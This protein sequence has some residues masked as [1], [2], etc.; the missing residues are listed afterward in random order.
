M[1]E[2]ISQLPSMDEK[3]F[4]QSSLSSEM[5]DEIK[6]VIQVTKQYN[7]EFEQVQRENNDILPDYVDQLEDQLQNDGV[8]I[9]DEVT[10]PE[11]K[12]KEQVFQLHDIP[13]EFT[14]DYLVLELPNQEEQRFEGEDALEEITLPSNK[15]GDFT[16]ELN[17]RLQEDLDANLQ[18]FDL[19]NEFAEWQWSL[20]QTNTEDE[21][22]NRNPDSHVTASQST[23]HTAAP[24]EL[25]DSDTAED[26]EEE[27]NSENNDE[28]DSEDKDDEN[29]ESEE[30]D[31]NDNDAE[32]NDSDE[33]D[34][35]T[36]E[37]EDKEE[38]KED[39][40]EEDSDSNENNDENDDSSEDKDDNDD[41]SEVEEV[42]VT[43]NH[44][45]HQVTKPI[46]D[47]TTE[48]LIHSVEDTI[49]PYQKLL[50][51]YETYFDI[52]L[53][54]EST[55]GDCAS[56]P[57]ESLKDMS[58]TNSLYLLYHETDEQDLLTDYIVD[59]IHED[60]QEEV[61]APFA[62]LEEEMD[63]YRTFIEVADE[64]A[65]KLVESAAA[66]Q[67]ESRD[68]NKNIEETMDDIAEWREQSTELID[69]Q[70]DLQGQSE[71]EQTAVLALEEDF[72]PIFTESQTLSDQATTN[73]ESASDVYQT[74]DRVNEQAESIQ[75]SGTEL[76]E[77][78]DNLSTNLTDK[79]EGDEAFAEN[80][81]NVLSN[82]RSGNRKNEDLGSLYN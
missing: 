35:K 9:T 14:V 43:N 81:S 74:F 76:V 59:E 60:I 62:S 8:K 15:E 27:S 44:I 24:P 20:D 31:T 40:E 49:A 63:S 70:A 66:A 69:N 17:L 71:E 16:V 61:R 75:Q 30:N 34:D 79:L 55:D 13:E 64:D 23:H 1:N 3:V 33:N 68:L 41:D 26:D 50:S 36:N 28:I 22:T 32:E 67:K 12:N 18:E 6:N 73:L 51:V 72:Q 45:R 5:T 29:N 42:E 46:I 10:L 65:E 47:E 4:E 80:F 25:M 11:N 56:V 38:D 21:E 57:D 54:C 48:E 52:Q 82:S 39:D 78:A 19:Y 77:D 53:S 2:Y 37:D 58:G 7:D